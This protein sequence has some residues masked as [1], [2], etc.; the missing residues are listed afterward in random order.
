M[1]AIHF[2]ISKHPYSS[3]QFRFLI[4]VSRVNPTLRP[5]LI[6]FLIDYFDQKS[7]RLFSFNQ[8]LEIGVIGFTTAIINWFKVRIVV[9]RK[10]S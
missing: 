5:V 6:A 9:M 4:R 3:D 10:E 1:I 7:I 8:C 2:L